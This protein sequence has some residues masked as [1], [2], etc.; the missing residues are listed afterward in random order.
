VTTK[1]IRWTRLLWTVLVTFYFVIFFR[2]LF[3]DAL[4]SQSWL[5]VLFFV[6][7]TLWMAFEY[8]FGSPFFQSGVVEPPRLWKTL[9]ALFFYPFLGFCVADNVW[10][11]WTQFPGLY[12]LVNLLGVALFLVGAGLRLSSLRTLLRSPSGKLV[13][14]SLF[15]FVRHPRY[16]GTLLQMLAAPL[17]FTSWLGLLLALAIGLPLILLEIRAEESGLRQSYAAEFDAWRQTVPALI[18]RL[19]AQLKSKP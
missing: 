17:V 16:L 9:F 13:R 15:R 4:S 2:N 1:T 11:H 18:P 7:F 3:R 12:P 14:S 8:Y 5:P 19:G 6:C 10:Q